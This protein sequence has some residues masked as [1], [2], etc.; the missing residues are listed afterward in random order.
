[1]YL[2]AVKY[3]LGLKMSVQLGGVSLKDFNNKP[4]K[5]K[6]AS[7]HGGIAFLRKRECVRK[8]L[9]GVRWH[10]WA[11]GYLFVVY[12]G[13]LLGSVEFDY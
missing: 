9:C 2:E 8:V 4:L 5:C 10:S 13:V 1:M 6:H 7:W 12:V 11:H 3:Q